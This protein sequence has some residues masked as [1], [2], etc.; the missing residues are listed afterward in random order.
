L[1]IAAYPRNGAGRSQLLVA[2]AICE[3]CGHS[4]ELELHEMHQMGVMVQVIQKQSH[5][6]PTLDLATSLSHDVTIRTDVCMDK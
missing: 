4:T 2:L 6:T 5:P 1:E 3:C